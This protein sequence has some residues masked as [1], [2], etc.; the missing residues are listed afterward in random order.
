MQ[1][2]IKLSVTSGCKSIAKKNISAIWRLDVCLILIQV[3]KRFLRGSLFWFNVVKIFMHFSEMGQESCPI[4]SYDVENQAA[5]KVKSQRNFSGGNKFIH[6]ISLRGQPPQKGD[7]MKNISGMTY[8]SIA[9]NL[10]VDN[11]TVWRKRQNLQKKYL[12]IAS[13]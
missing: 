12:A 10:G 7:V 8:C 11:T 13:H 3:V 2:V 1:C 6:R 9:R 4:F 5:K